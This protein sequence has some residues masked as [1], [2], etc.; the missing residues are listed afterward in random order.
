M[1][2]VCNNSQFRVENVVHADQKYENSPQK[3]KKKVPKKQMLKS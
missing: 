1:V 3:K 2:I